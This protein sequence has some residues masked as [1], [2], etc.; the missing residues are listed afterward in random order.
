MRKRTVLDYWEATNAMR[1]HYVHDVYN[2]QPY[3][4]AKWIVILK[5][6]S[7]MAKRV[8]LTRWLLT[9]MK[10][11]QVTFELVQ[12]TLLKRMF[13]FV[14]SETPIKSITCDVK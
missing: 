11:K 7:T 3:R 2:T 9:K 6:V 1:E 13:A 14:T 5:Q 10:Y 4:Q 12:I 8:T